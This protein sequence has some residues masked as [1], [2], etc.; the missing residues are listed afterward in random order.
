MDENMTMHEGI[1]KK[2]GGVWKYPKAPSKFTGFYLKFPWTPGILLEFY[3]NFT[4]QPKIMTK[5]IPKT[6]FYVTE[7]RFSKKIIPKQC[8]M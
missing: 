2:G 4:L 8:F 5:S 6:L 7:M 3:W 1:K